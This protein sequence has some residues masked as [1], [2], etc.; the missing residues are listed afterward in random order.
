VFV[1]APRNEVLDAIRIS[2][3]GCVQLHGEEKP[4]D[5]E[6]YPIPV[7]KAFRVGQDFDSRILGQ[8]K[9]SA[10][11]LD[12]FVNGQHGGTRKT[13]D[14]RIAVDAKRYGRIILS[15]GITPENVLEAMRTVRPYAIDVNSGVESSPGRKD[16]ARLQQLFATVRQLSE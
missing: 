3:I 9:T 7:Y 4:E 15:G 10:Y 13:F 14:W 2:G 5:A 12:T 1:N 11:L 8:Y 16:K 6:G